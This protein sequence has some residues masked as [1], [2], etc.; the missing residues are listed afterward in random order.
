[1]SRKHHVAAV[2][3]DLLINSYI[4]EEEGRGYLSLSAYYVV[5]YTL[6]ESHVLCC[7]VFIKTLWLGV[8]IIVAVVS[9]FFPFFFFLATLCSL[10]DLSSPPRDRTCALVNESAET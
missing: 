6:S 9:L 10:W 8:T 1:M 7:V 5:N 4:N 3:N 2:A